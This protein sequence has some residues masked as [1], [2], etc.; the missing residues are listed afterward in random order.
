[1]RLMTRCLALVMLLSFAAPAAYATP[2]VQEVKWRDMSAW[3]VSDDTLPLLTIEMSWR[4][5][6]AGESRAGVSMLMTR[7][8]NEGAGA[9]DA[10]TFQ[11][12][13][14]D[15]AISL[16]FGADDDYVTAS[17]RCLTRYRAACF[18]LLKLALQTPRF[19]DDAI[20]R[21]KAE[22]AAALRNV[23]Q[24]P[25][26]L[27]SEAFQ[28]LA[29]PGHAYG[30]STNGTM[31]S[32]A[33]ITRE[34]II[35]RHKS[36]YARDNLQL[37]IVGDMSRA[38]ARR[39]MRDVFAALPAKST[40]PPHNKVMATNGPNT[41]HIQRSG[42]QTTLLFGHQGIGYDHELFFPAFVMNAIL[43]GSGFSSRLTEAVR[44]K[45]GLAYGVYSYWAVGRYG[46]TWRGSVASDNATAQQALDVIRAEMRRMAKDGVTD[47]RLDAA[48]TY[49]TGAY[50]L[51]FDSGKKIAAQLIGLQEMGRPI[52][53]LRDRNLAIK[54]V[55]REQIK[56]A[57]ALLMADGLIVVSVGETA[58]TLAPPQ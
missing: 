42:P 15:R 54:A 11:T 50:A 27:A 9:M 12:A 58:V 22:Q 41:K 51:R 57:A 30:R 2:P 45:R 31:E 5:G 24:S 53:Y 35:A 49:L 6:T 1:M 13:L 48:K 25:R 17:L 56:R 43:G 28:K 7:L 37:A 47:A 8:M 52:S 33:S 23:Q 3:L 39:F 14:G 55:T 21:M 4:G 36:V 44:E 40:V 26:G 29:Y 10:Q 34:E 46:A 16:S 20:V 38:E 32:L 19:D 18:A